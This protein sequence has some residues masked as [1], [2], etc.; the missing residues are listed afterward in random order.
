MNGM[1]DDNGF[2]FNGA[3]A[4]LKL[5]AGPT[6]DIHPPHKDWLAGRLDGIRRELD[7][8]EGDLKTLK[9]QAGVTP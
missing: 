5:K 2:D 9:I 8:I 4:A 7:R 1:P 6:S 3:L